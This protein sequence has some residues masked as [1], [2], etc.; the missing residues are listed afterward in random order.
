MDNVTVYDELQPRDVQAIDNMELDMSIL[1]TAARETPN[2]VTSAGLEA[3][4]SQKVEQIGKDA[5]GVNFS[6]KL[7]EAR[8]TVP[9]MDTLYPIF[10]SLQE[11]FSTPTK[12]FEASNLASFK[13]SLTSTL[14]KFKQVHQD[15][16]SRG[17]SKPIDENQRS[18]KRKRGT[19]NE[20]MASSFNPKYLTSRDL[21][22]LEVCFRLYCIPLKPKL[23]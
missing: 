9:D 16:E 5:T 14:S 8:A 18:L 6:D 22:D 11:C 20:E 19:A 2:Q 15:L 12:L 10:W 21:F 17:A 3:I 4:E 13:S 1:S 7:V 23:P